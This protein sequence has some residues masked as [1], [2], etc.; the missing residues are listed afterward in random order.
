MEEVRTFAPLLVVIFLAFAIPMLLARFKRFMIPVVVGEILA[1]ILVGRSGF[2]WVEHHDPVLDL[3]AEVGFVFLMFLAGL[4]IDFS[5]LGGL[6]SARGGSGKRRLW[7]PLSLAVVNFALTLGLSVLLALGLSA[8]GLTQNVVLMALILSTT[9]LGV[10]LPVLKER[11]MTTG[12]FGQSVLIS[13]LIADFATML[14]ITVDV[15]I[16]SQGLTLDILLIGA[17]FVVFFLVYRFG[18][19]FFNKLPMVR[20]G[21]GRTQPCH[22]SDQSARGLYDD[23]C[24]CCALGDARHRAHSGRFSGRGYGRAAAN[25]GG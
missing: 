12:R 18:N 2:R 10:V 15:A 24:F 11:G 4:E 8:I 23:V 7:S 9:S 16:L 20:S 21:I 22:G 6:V 14:L 5:S 25:P 1:G 13:A 3:L 19:F 17:L